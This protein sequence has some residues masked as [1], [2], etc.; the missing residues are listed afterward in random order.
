MRGDS[1]QH[2]LRSFENVTICETKDRERVFLHQPVTNPIA[3]GLPFF[4]MIGAIAFDHE[5]R[6]PSRFASPPAHDLPQ[7]PCSD[8]TF[9]SCTCMRMPGDLFPQVEYAHI[10]IGQAGRLSP[11][12]RGLFRSESDK[13]GGLSPPDVTIPTLQ[14][15][16]GNPKFEIYPASF[17]AAFSSV[18]TLCSE[19]ASA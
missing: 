18:F 4:S 13:H 10:G 14:S 2:E 9:S 11:P 7:A 16:I 15:E 1:I 17:I 6:L 5:T 3:L 8:T 12:W 19:S